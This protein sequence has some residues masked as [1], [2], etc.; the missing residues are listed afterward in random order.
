[1]GYEFV[2]RDELS[3]ICCSLYCHYA[4]AMDSGEPVPDT[5]NIR[6]QKM[7]SFIHEHFNENLDLAQIA[8]AAD[9]GERECLRCF[10][11]AIQTSPM[12]Y[13]LKYRVTQ[14]ASMLLRSPGS[15][16]STIAGMCGFNSPSNFSQMFGRF[17]KCTPREYRRDK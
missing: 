6:I 7:I 10:K 3:R 12:Q 9:I 8:R 4:H 15:S 14:G 11:R 16:I 17:F 13:L 1:M 2:V 5:D